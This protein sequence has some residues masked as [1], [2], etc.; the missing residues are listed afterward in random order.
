MKKI[1]CIDFDGVLNNYKYYDEDELFTPREGAKEFLENLAKDYIVFILT[2]RN[3]AKVERWLN[4]YDMMEHVAHVTNIKP[5]ATVYLDDR[6]VRYDGDFNAAE[7]KIRNFKT[8]WE[9]E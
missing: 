3:F 8:F 9:E 4:K 2:A 5:P 6:A 1:I 7:E